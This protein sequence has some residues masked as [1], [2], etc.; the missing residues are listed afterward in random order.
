MGVVFWY[1]SINH[2]DRNSKKGKIYLIM[3]RLTVF[4]RGKATSLERYVMIG[5]LRN[6]EVNRCNQ[7]E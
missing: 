1:S 4:E 6:L 2:I 5:R 7:G 3:D